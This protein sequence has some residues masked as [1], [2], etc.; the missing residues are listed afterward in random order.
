MINDSDLDEQLS[1]LDSTAE[2]QSEPVD[3][4]TLADR[5]FEEIQDAIVT[6]SIAPGTKITE[7]G[8]AKQYGISRGPLREAMRR[9]E[10]RH[11]VTRIPHIGARVVSLSLEELLE[12]Y[13]VREAMEGMACRLAARQMPQV[14]I[15]SLK[16]LL[17]KHEQQAELQENI[18]YYQKEGDLD[19]H[20]RIVLG[21]GN[22][23]L[24]ELLCG[25]LYYLV[26]MYRY[27][28]SAT[29]GRPQRAFT[30][31]HRIVDAIEQR[32]EEL[33]EMLMRRHIRASRDN[34]EQRL[35]E[36]AGQTTP[37]NRILNKRKQT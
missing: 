16:A 34:V 26:R 12:L 36:A 35:R 7:P 30:E 25:E 17:Q 3:G 15:D 37:E 8:L 23:K 1:A 11:L 22:K 24:M 31:H 32:D 28:F 10:G 9:L 6:G 2:L 33:A 27:R 5:V 4:R 18:A 14:E 21:S 13:E 19:F 20:Y 29:S